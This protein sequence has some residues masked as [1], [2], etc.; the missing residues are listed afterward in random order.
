MDDST[1]FI[2]IAVIGGTLLG[3][4]FAILSFFLVDLLKRFESTAL[5]VFRSQDTY[6]EPSAHL[7]MPESLKDIELFDGDP[8]VIFIAFSSAVTWIL[9]LFPLVLG[10]TAAWTGARPLILGT[11]LVIL[12]SFFGLS[13]FNRNAAIKKLRPYLT[14]EEQAWPLLGW[15]LLAIYVGAAL[16]V[17]STAS[18]NL[19][20]LA[21]WTE[22]MQNKE[23][24][25]AIVKIFCILSLLIGTY[26]TNKDMF[27]FFKS[28]AGERMRQRWLEWFV[29]SRY[30]HLKGKVQHSVPRLTPKDRIT[31]E[32]RWNGGRPEM[33]ST[34]DAF[35]GTA[36]PLLQTVWDEVISG[37]RG[38]PSWMLDVPAI[39]NWAAEV[40]HLADK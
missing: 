15:I 2:N 38:A 12:D 9:F 16:V 4:V 39:A 22:N 29:S 36:Q 24:A 1:Y 11:E 26:T 18:P 31:L 27:I 25:I 6:T 14:R 32:T 17:L 8:L 7:T 10:L 13:F 34:H 30:P 5:P 19:P 33:I 37:R 23:L 28:I 20:H 21:F 3:L 40:E 35:R